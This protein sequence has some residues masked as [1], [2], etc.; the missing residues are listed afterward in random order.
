MLIIR[1]IILGLPV[2]FLLQVI[3]LLFTNY[4]L[5]YL[6]VTKNKISKRKTNDLKKASK[7]KLF[8]IVI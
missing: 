2:C 3:S 8:M 6:N 7:E 5:K 4:Y 1:K